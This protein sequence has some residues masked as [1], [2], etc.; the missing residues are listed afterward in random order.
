M[1]TPSGGDIEER[2]FSPDQELVAPHLIDFEVLHTLRRHYLI[3]KLTTERRP[4]HPVGPP[5]ANP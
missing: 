2:L 5:P 3:G 4:A 1:A